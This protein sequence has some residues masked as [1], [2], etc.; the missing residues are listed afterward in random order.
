LQKSYALFDFD[1]TLI[2]GDSIIRMCFFARRRKLMTLGQLL[3]SGFQAALYLCHL[4]TAQKSKQ[5]AL[6]FMKGKSEKEMEALARD[7]CRDVLLPRL[8]PNGVAELKRHRAEGREIWLI[9]ASPA[10]YLEPLMEHLPIT[11][12]IGTRMHTDE[13]G[14]YTGLMAGENCRG[15]EKPLRLAEVLASRGDMLD[16]AGSWAYGDTAGDAPMLSLCAQKVAVN[17]RRKLLRELDGADGV[18][19]VRWK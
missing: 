8:Y 11:G 19:T 2:R 12:V 17:P 13:N 9:S 6:A 7:F 16:Y 15:I 10:F 14:V 18:V 4:T 3:A 5:A 1:G